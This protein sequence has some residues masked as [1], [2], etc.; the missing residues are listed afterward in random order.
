MK[1]FSK[2]ALIKAA[3][4]VAFLLAALAILR[5]SPLRTWLDPA[6]IGPVIDH[7][8]FWGPV[9]FILFYAAALCLLVPSSIL[10]MLGAA[11]FGVYLGFLYVWTGAII[12]ASAAFLIARTL[13]R[14]FASALIGTRLQRFDRAFEKNGF[15]A[16]LYIRLLNTPFTYVNFGIGLTGVPFGQY[17]SA[18][19]IGMVISLFT[20]V[21]LGSNLK[22]AWVTGQWSTLFSGK[23][24]AVMSLYAF[25]FFIPRLLQKLKFI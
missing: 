1:P 17:V 14:D 21:F 4:L 10:S 19:A 11:L 8:G 15:T 24:I 22:E 13:G 23:A 2:H 5:F 20:F 7:F 16:V 9:A 18:T 6:S 12:G 3:G 25:S